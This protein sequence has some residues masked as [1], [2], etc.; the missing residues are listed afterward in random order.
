VKYTLHGKP[1]EFGGYPVLVTKNA[2]YLPEDMSINNEFACFEHPEMLEYYRLNIDDA[3]SARVV[4]RTEA[5][6]QDDR[7]KHPM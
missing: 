4:S 7:E 6:F 3:I 5:H 2:V 1:A